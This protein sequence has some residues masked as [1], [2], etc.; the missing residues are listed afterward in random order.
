MFGE[1]HPLS[2][3]VGPVKIIWGLSFTQILAIGVG[4]SL[5]YKLAR[6]IP[7]LPVGNL[8]LAHI[9]HMAPLAAAVVLTMARE[10]KTGLNLAVYLAYLIAFKLR[11][12]VFV[13]RRS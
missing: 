8:L 1:H 2:P 10:R 7:P 3:K 9:H 6:I 11:R 13:W 12:K 4:A 5:S